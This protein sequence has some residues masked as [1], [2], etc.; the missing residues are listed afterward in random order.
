VTNTARVQASPAAGATKRV[1]SSGAS[2][3]VGGGYGNFNWI[4]W[5]NAWA[6]CWRGINLASGATSVSPATDVVPRVSPLPFFGGGALYFDDGHVLFGDV[7]D[8]TGS[9]TVE[10]WIKPTVV[11][12]AG[13]RVVIKDAGAAGG[14]ALS[15]GDPGSGK[16]RFFHR[17]ANTVSTDTDA[18]VVAGVWQHVAGVFNADDD[19]TR[20][21]VDGVQRA[22][23]TG[24]TNPIMGSTGL[25][26]IG[27]QPEFPNFYFTGRIDDVRLWSVARTQEQIATN[28]HVRIAQNEAGLVGLWRFED[29]S[30]TTV[31]DSSLSGNNGTIVG[32]VAR[33]ASLVTKRVAA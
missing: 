33:V 4:G 12:R 9:F 27:R 24:Q 26:A 31:L 25:L 19:T 7:L 22:V 14:W 18:V 8:Q 2:A 23:A 11:D 3:G 28:M 21:Y 6:N 17:D 29:T 15:L 20:V 10:A 13:S 1:A 16:L 5:G 32:N 30:E